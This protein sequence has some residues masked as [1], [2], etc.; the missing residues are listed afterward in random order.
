[1]YF[2]VTLKFCLSS[3]FCISVDG[4]VFFITIYFFISLS[5]SPFNHEYL[6]SKKTVYSFHPKGDDSTAGKESCSH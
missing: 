5:L 1:M 2:P 3:I 6:Q 4:N